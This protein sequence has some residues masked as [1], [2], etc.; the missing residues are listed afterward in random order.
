[1]SFCTAINCMDGR[2]QLPVTAFMRKRFAS[3]YVDVVTEPGP[4]LILSDRQD[5]TLVESILRR[6]DI[7]IKVHKSKGIAIVAHAD[8]AGNPGRK[9][10]QL[11]DL[12][13][14]ESFLTC[15]YPAMNIIA[16]WVN[17]KWEVEEMDLSQRAGLKA[18]P[19]TD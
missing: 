14:A 19:R 13:N 1:V 6:V 2:V 12:R 18:M 16:L 15:R 10:K 17:K 3:L 8:C 9:S 11:I 4:S 7:S 5:W